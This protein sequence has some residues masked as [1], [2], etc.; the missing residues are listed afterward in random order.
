MA[1]RRSGNGECGGE[2]AVAGAAAMAGR[3]DGEPASGETGGG[4]SVA[5]AHG[6]N[7]PTAVCT[8]VESGPYDGQGFDGL[9]K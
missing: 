3:R 4:G 6:S 8:F 1:R 9:D 5:L 2:G 7:T